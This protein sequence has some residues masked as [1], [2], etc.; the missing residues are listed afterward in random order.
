MS[1]TEQMRIVNGARRGIHGFFDA[2]SDM[3]PV[4]RQDKLNE[5]RELWDKL[6]SNK[7][8]MNPSEKCDVLLRTYRASAMLTSDGFVRSTETTRFENIDKF[9]TDAVEREDTLSETK[10]DN[11]GA[12]LTDVPL[13]RMPTDSIHNGTS[14]DCDGGSM[15]AKYGHAMRVMT[16]ILNRDFRY[17]D[18]PEFLAPA[19]NESSDNLRRMTPETAQMFQ[20]AWEQDIGDYLE[21][22]K[23]FRE[24][25]NPAILNVMQK[26]GVGNV[27]AYNWFAAQGAEPEQRVE[28]SQNRIFMSEMYPLFYAAL[29][30]LKDFT[31][32]DA[33]TAGDLECVEACL[34]RKFAV[35]ED[36]LRQ[37]R[38]IQ[39]Y[40]IG[41]PHSISSNLLKNSGFLTSAMIPDLNE[42]DPE[43]RRD[44]IRM[45]FVV[46]ELENELSM[47]TPGGVRVRFSSLNEQ[48]YVPYDDVK[49]AISNARDVSAWLYSIIN[50][51]A[52]A[53]AVT[54][55]AHDV[56]SFRLP[57]IMKL[58]ANGQPLKKVVDLINETADRMQGDYAYIKMRCPERNTPITMEW[59]SMF[60]VPGIQLATG[61]TATVLTSLASM[62]EAFEESGCFMA[63]AA[64]MAYETTRNYV[65]IRNRDD[66]LLGIILVEPMDLVKSASVERNGM[67][68]PGGVLSVTPIAGATPGDIDELYKGLDDMRKTIADNPERINTYYIEAECNAR[69]ALL[70]EHVSGG[71]AVRKAAIYCHGIRVDR[72]NFMNFINRLSYA[73]PDEL[74]AAQDR[75]DFIIKA[76]S[77]AGVNDELAQEEVAARS[78]ERGHHDGY[79]ADERFLRVV[80]APDIA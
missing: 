31:L 48:E 77:L 58:V 60:R 5:A 43:T 76:N 23:K 75:N 7:I 42:M 79:V 29:T 61:G 12:F 22:L 26:S 62:H 39:P 65:S 55:T 63:T 4:D 71:A 70:S 10:W 3:V 69:K 44:F 35:T 11:K 67:D 47:S 2:L 14:L 15:R 45:S 21:M 1:T 46:S 18:C 30:D 13:T 34:A 56:T 64:G 9:Y 41:Y 27:Y 20:K 52:N 51:P 80:S 24:A 16:F 57:H 17:E 59:A 53:T 74:A 72:E 6:Y 38:G 33:V 32:Q 54:G 78:T 49:R 19:L 28:T 50:I 37:F 68:L 25:L 8:I 40:D 36:R 73:L 66:K